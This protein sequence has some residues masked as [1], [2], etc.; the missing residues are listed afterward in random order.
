[1]YPLIGVSLAILALVAAIAALFGAVSFSPLA[2]LAS[3]LVFTGV[4]VLSSLGLGKLYGVYPHL[5]SAVITAFIL[6]MLFN[7]TLSPLMLAQ[8]AL[9]ALV[10]Q[11]SKYV[12]AHKRRH[13][14]N[15]AAFGAFVGGLLQLQFASWWIG[16]PVFATFVAIAG[17]LILYKTRQ[18]LTA[19]VFLGIS[20]TIFTL[21]GVPIVTAVLSYPL[22]FFAGFMLSEPLTLPPKRWQRL[23]VAA[24]MAL[25]VSL[26]FNILF[27]YSSPEFAIVAG[28]ILAF[29][30]AFK[31]RKGLQLTL[32]RRTPLSATAVEYA[33]A[34]PA[35]AYFEAGQYVE[36]TVPHSKFDSRGVR[37]YFSVTSA[38]RTNELT[39]GI[40]F[41]QPSSTFK[42]ALS[43]LPLGSSVQATGITGGFTL[44]RDPKQK[45]LFVAGGI[46]ITPFIS[47]IQSL[48]Q[49]QRD[50]TLLYFVNSEQE[51]AYSDLLGV[52]NVTVHYFVGSSSKLTSEIVQEYVTDASSRVAY[53][54][55]PPAMVASSK[56]VL[57]GT[58]K[59]IKADYF[60]G[61]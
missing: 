5:P 61:Y 57:R 29:A 59:S 27:F 28:N 47:H 32:V 43:A 45:L 22:L 14:V 39:L 41:Y 37:R 18:L 31:W 21:S 58:V 48:G 24:A 51:K 54:S 25:I 46:G 6:A 26:P 36:L 40:K 19:S 34:T 35:P 60:S 53:V 17:F 42:Q 9:I 3:I 12:I 4:S 44:P 56:Q 33:F 13:I 11:A 1:M 10:A 16:S 23:T 50:I 38:P 30:L 2:V 52:S 7:P 15:P 20:L 55:G 8:Y 49:Q